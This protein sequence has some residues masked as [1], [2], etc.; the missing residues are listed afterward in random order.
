MFRARTMT[1]HGHT[2]E[3]LPIEKITEILK[4]YGAIK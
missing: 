3:A 4:K 1:A 2:V